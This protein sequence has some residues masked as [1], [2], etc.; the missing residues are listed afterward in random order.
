MN[1]SSTSVGALYLQEIKDCSHPEQKRC[2]FILKIIMEVMETWNSWRSENPHPYP[3][4]RGAD[5]SE[6]NLGE[7]AS[8]C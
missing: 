5:L 7:R 4:L 3:D 1:Y 8:R 6:A 2:T